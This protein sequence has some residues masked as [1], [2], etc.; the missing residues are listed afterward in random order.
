MEKPINYISLNEC[1]NRCQE[2][3]TKRLPKI[4]YNRII[5]ED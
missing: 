3:L 2:E 4:L 5:I 1:E